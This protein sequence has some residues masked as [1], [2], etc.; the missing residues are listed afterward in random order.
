[1]LRSGLVFTS[2]ATLGASLLTLGTPGFAQ[3][4]DD[5]D[6]LAEKA[7]AT[8]ENQAEL[9]AE[10]PADTQG[11]ML[12]LNNAADIQHEIR[13]GNGEDGEVTVQDACRMTYVITNRSAEPLRNA[14]WQVGVFDG[15]GV[16]RALLMLGFGDLPTDKTKIG[17]FD[18]PDWPCEDISRIIVNDA[19]E[20][21]PADAELVEMPSG[22]SGYTQSD[23][24]LTGLTTSS[25][26]EI[27]F[28]L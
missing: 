1:M 15:A 11:I 20:C 25:R 6:K 27:E 26:A 23:I 8:A 3:D 14:V 21:T 2:I 18:I 16:V 9:S 10:P 12:E 22:Q 19:A 24:C 5:A 13:T 7:A 17:V 28:G 4:A